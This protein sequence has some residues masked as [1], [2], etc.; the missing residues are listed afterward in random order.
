MLT[1]S[2]PRTA[3]KTQTGGHEA[4]SASAAHPSATRTKKTKQT[5]LKKPAKIGIAVGVPLGVV[6]IVGAIVAYVVGKRRGRKRRVDDPTAGANK[7]IKDPSNELNIPPP[8]PDAVELP[9]VRSQELGDQQRS[10]LTWWKPF[11]RIRRTSKDYTVPPDAP[12]S[13][14]ELP[15]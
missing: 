8:T 15:A 2:R 4:T 10:S 13:P 6:A 7:L 9:T 3:S 5:G 11:G 12:Q 1:L 14:L